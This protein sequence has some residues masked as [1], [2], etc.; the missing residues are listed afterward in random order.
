MCSYNRVNGSYGYQILKTLNG[1]LKDKLSFQDY[2]SPPAPPS[3]QRRSP[4]LPPKIHLGPPIRPRPPANIRT[5]AFPIRTLSATGIA[6]LKTKT[7]TVPL[8]RPTNLAVLSNA[9]TI[10]LTSDI[11]TGNYATS[12]HH[13][14]HIRHRHRQLRN[15]PLQLRTPAARRNQS[16]L[17]GAVQ[18]RSSPLFHGGSDA[19][20]GGLRAAAAGV[21]GPGPRRARTA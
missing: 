13:L 1:L 6:L 19:G 5:P 14:P 8:T 12:R 7:A 20:A 4:Q 15:Q 16:A 3:T 9:D 11:A 2:V 17:V 18:T 21:L 10:S